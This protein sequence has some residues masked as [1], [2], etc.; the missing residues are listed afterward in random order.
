MDHLCHKKRTFLLVVDHGSRYVEI[1]KLETSTTSAEVIERL[2][3]IFARHGIPEILVSD[4]GPQFS[5]AEFAKFG[6][7]C[8]FT[9]VTSSPS[10]PQSNGEAEGAVETVKKLLDKASDPYMA[11]LCYR[12]TPLHNGFSPAQLLMGR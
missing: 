9:H 5:S 3:S 6:N 8:G 10:F 2:R 12:T 11:L 7:S 1:A 4:N